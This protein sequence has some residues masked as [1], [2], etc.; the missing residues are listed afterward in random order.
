[1][2]DNKR[3]NEVLQLNTGHCAEEAEGSRRGLFVKELAWLTSFSGSAAFLESKDI[4]DRNGM[5]V[6]ELFH[7]HV[8][9]NHL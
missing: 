2:R 6:Q 8:F 7:I 5:Y 1:M 9:K 3:W 4:V